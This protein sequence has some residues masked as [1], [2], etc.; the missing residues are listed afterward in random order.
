MAADPEA[1]D[2]ASTEGGRGEV[3]GAQRG[4]DRGGGVD[5]HPEEILPRHSGAQLLL[6]GQRH[7]HCQRPQSDEHDDG[8]E[9]MLQPPLP[10]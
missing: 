1:D 4:N 2:V 8:T 9:K 7:V 3:A 10:H 6:P 5:E